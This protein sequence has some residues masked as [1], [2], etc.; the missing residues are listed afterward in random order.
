MGVTSLL[1]Y[2]D[3]RSYLRDEYRGRKAVHSFYSFRLFSQRAGFRSPNF[4]KLVMDGE[5]NLTKESVFKFSR[6]LGHNRK[7]SE[8]FEN[9]V[10][11]NQSK[12]LEEK[13]IYLTK[14]MRLRR[15]TEPSRD[16]ESEYAFYAKWYHPV[17]RELVTALDFR[18]DFRKLAQSVAPSITTAEARRSV[19]LLSQLGFIEKT[20]DGG[21]TKTSATLS[22]GAQVRSVATANYQR[23]VMELAQYAMERFGASQRTIHS[24]TLS[25]SQQTYEEL[26][27]RLQELRHDILRLVGANERAERVVQL[28]F[29][30][31]PVSTADS[32]SPSPHEC[33]G[34]TGVNILPT[35]SR[36]S[37]ALEPGDRGVV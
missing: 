27:G 35:S 11:F 1:E 25:V 5:R 9:L 36:H 15:K 28:N 22:S 30:L 6:G 2:M 12:T 3:Y 21:Y 17:V 7:E 14:M 18:G 4:L 23:A 24:L 33:G 37:A 8:Y 32:R 26:A 34:A 19:K 31:F 13:N 20:P 16:E 29:Q 10:F